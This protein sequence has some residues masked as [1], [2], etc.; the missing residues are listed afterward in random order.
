MFN[1]HGNLGWKV[2]KKGGPI[3]QL[4]TNEH[5]QKMKM[6]EESPEYGT[7]HTGVYLGEKPPRL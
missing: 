2:R 7:G 1:D 3:F 5:L 4:A 6:V